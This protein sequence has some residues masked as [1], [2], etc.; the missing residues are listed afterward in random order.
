MFGLTTILSRHYDGT[1]VQFLFLAC[2]PINL[3]RKW[4]KL[5]TN[6]ATILTLRPN[7]Q[8]RID[9][10]KIQ[11]LQKTRGYYVSSGHLRS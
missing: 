2:D 3:A 6:H 9:S 4:R 8:R 10:W 5:Q 7:S 11:K 1:Y